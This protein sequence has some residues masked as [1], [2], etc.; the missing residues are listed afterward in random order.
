MYKRQSQPIT[1]GLED[2]ELN[3]PYELVISTNGGLWRYRLEDTIIFTSILPFK[4]KVIGRTQQFINLV[5]EELMIQHV[6][7][8]IKEAAEKCNCIV[9][10]FTLAPYLE[11]TNKSIG[12]HYWVI[13]FVTNPNDLIRF[14]KVLDNELQKTNIDYKAK[15]INNSPLKA[16]VIKVVQKNTFYRWLKSKNKL[17]GQNKIPRLSTTKQ[18]INEILEMDINN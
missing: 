6:E 15:R 1:L 17:G 4:I 14:S 10:E 12:F 16:P 18:Y 5:G 7:K 11:A 13:E 2:V 3:T 9:G 8:A